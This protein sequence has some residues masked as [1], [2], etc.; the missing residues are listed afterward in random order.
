MR[1]PVPQAVEERHL[2][3][4]N[5]RQFEA[6]DGLRALGI[7]AV[8]LHHMGHGNRFMDRGLGVTLFFVLTG[9]VITALLLRERREAGTVSC[10]PFYARRALRTLPL[11]Y[12][13]L[14]IYVV[15]VRL[16]ES[17]TPAG[18][19]F[20]GNLPAYLSLT[21]DWF[22]RPEGRHSIF[23][24]AWS[25]AAQEKFYL[26]APLLVRYARPAWVPPLA[27]GAGLVAGE[28]A[29]WGLAAGY[30][31]PAGLGVR[32]LASIPGPICLGSLAAYALEEAAGFRR[33][34]AVAGRGWS[35]PAAAA[36]LALPS[37]LELGEL[38]YLVTSAGM[39]LLVAACVVRPENALRPLLTCAPARWLG[40]VSYGFYLMHMLAFHAV[41]RALPSRGPV[42]L[43][44]VSA[45]T[46][47]LA[48]GLSWNLF[49]RPVI[50]AGKRWLLRRRL[51]AGPLAQEVVLA[52]T[53]KA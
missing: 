27:L 17:G 16:L 2:A 35:L 45:S 34:W 44:V 43:F 4:R 39:V 42:L 14:A 9:F 31:A 28:A 6:L 52:P 24:F 47:A 32:V 20:F 23:Y 22:V 1:L 19:R 11:Y 50:E 36:L 38:Q 51:P 37:M 33:A 12:A 46:A 40:K 29:R 15:L 30:L 25:L 18:S 21:S 8:L 41:R 26:L 10:L 7:L 49:E 48:A 3:Y 5:A 13:V 53:R